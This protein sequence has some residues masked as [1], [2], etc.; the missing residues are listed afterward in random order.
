MEWKTAMKANDLK[1]GQMKIVSIVDKLIVLTQVDGK[2]YA[3]D[4]TCTHKHCSLGE[5]FLEGT[6]VECPCH[7]ARFDVTQGQVVSLPATLP[8]KTYAVK[9]ENGALLVEV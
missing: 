1:N 7:G 3:F 2:Y 5:G 6:V 8:I 9:E 4:D